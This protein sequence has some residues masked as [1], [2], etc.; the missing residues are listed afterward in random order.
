MKTTDAGELS[1]EQRS[2][3]SAL[4]AGDVA[5]IAGPGSGKTH[6]LVAAVR[7]ALDGAPSSRIICLTFTNKA[8]DNLKRQL[9]T[10]PNLF[11]GTFHAL[12]ATLL[13][14]NPPHKLADAE[15]IYALLSGLKRSQSLRAASV[16]E[17]GLLISRCKNGSL[18]S[19]DA[20]YATAEYDAALRRRDLIDY[21]DLILQA[22]EQ[23]ANVPP[24]DYL[25]VDEFQDTSPKQYELLQKLRGERTKLFVIGDPRQSIYRFRGADGSVFDRLQADARIRTVTLS[26]N[27]RSSRRVVA[28]A[29][30]IFAAQAT[31]TAQRTQDGSAIGVET[32]D[33]YSEP[34]YAANV[35]QQA[36]GG[37]E[38]HYTHHDAPALEAAS[39]RDFAVLYRTRRQG[40]LL[41]RKLRQAGLPVQRLGE[42]SP[43]AT[44]LMRL[45]TAALSFV[46]S[47]DEAA[48]LAVEQTAAAA[49]LK[50][51]PDQLRRLDA[52]KSPAEA[53][54]DLAENLGQADTDTAVQLENLSARF[55]SLTGLID[56]LRSLAEQ[57]FF[58]PAADAVCLSTIHASKG[59]EFR[60]V[61]VAGCN[62][63]VLP[64]SR[65]ED[66]EGLAEE[67][68][69]FYVALT[70][71]R[72][73]LTL[74]HT[75][76]WG[77]QA[78][79]PSPFIGL[80]AVP[81]T[82]DP[83]LTGTERARAR[84]RRRRAQQKLF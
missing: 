17:L 32:L 74:L 1:D 68:R 45:F 25:F 64:S 22:V 34:E 59:L 3:L 58:D 76:T 8:A 9:P 49:K 50:V 83:S 13:P 60:H 82:I 55:E 11:V 14:G 51:K 33:E 39:F 56:Y 67:R 42:D 7:Q 28:A 61:F 78:A 15:T 52:S 19:E 36:L 66:P 57:D 5:V 38:W 35:I 77:G 79:K 21:D 81:A 70:R 16:H 44:P 4:E 75:R 26:R 20:R 63:G 73:S 80:A 24:G 69:L 6:T 10:G 47:P 41:A 23:A 53:A 30:R 2:A 12:A 18:D 31:Q 37:T 48:K 40:E 29:N 46:E 65:A 27:Y 54:G 43:Y 71:A 62:D 84:Q 72:D